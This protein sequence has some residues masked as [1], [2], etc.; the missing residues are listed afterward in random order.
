MQTL[1]NWFINFV[2][3][4][5]SIDLSQYFINESKNL[6]IFKSVEQ[7]KLYNLS[8][9]TFFPHFSL[10]TMKNIQFSVKKLVIFYMYVQKEETCW[11]VLAYN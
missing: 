5:Q 3:H 8:M 4:F 10:K 6:D 2:Y 1:Y 11:E 9:V 7:M